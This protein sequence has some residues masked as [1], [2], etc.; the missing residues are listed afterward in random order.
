LQIA[1]TVIGIA[2]LNFALVH[3][4]PG[5]PVRLMAG[6][7]GSADALTLQQT[8]HELGLD[9]PIWEQLASQVGRTMRGDLGIS[10]RQRRP[11]AQLILERLPATLVL[12]GAALILA[13]IVGCSLGTLAALRHGSWTDGL[14][15]LGALL[16]YATPTFWV[17]LI[18]VLV[19]SVWLDW[20]PAYGSAS[21]LSHG[22]TARD[23]VTD[24][25]RHAALP[26]ASLGL[27][28]AATYARLA[29][30]AVL[31]V[32]RSD[33]VR[34]AT[35]K[36]LPGWRIVFAHIL[37]NASLPVVTLIGLQVGQLVSGSVVVETIFAW[38]GIGRLAFEAL[39]QRDYPVL[40]GVFFVTSLLVITANILTDATYGLIDP[41]T[42]LRLA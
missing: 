9:R 2:V 13:I 27:Y 19:F 5:D 7:A 16:F 24:A 28:Y 20:L 23:A 31:G 11:V 37:R 18:L 8:R 41:R 14:V 10:F 36:G 25:V 30:T 34:T 32:A 33:F 15:R 22:A 6:D 1:G 29:R 4:A 3:L 17:A 39:T 21:I 38:P 12:T 35:A 26:V 40:L 42:R